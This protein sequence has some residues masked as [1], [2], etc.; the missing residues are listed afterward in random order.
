MQFFMLDI[1]HILIRIKHF[2]TGGAS[3]EAPFNTID[4]KAAGSLL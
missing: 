2:I 3:V 4:T 1:I